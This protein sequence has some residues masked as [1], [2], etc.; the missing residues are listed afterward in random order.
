[1]SGGIRH[2]TQKSDAFTKGRWSKANG[3][4]ICESSLANMTSGA[5]IMNIVKTLIAAI[6]LNLP[7]ITAVAAAAEPMKLQIA[8]TGIETPKGAIMMV[9]FDSEAA[10][11]A[12]K[13]VR[14]VM[15][16]AD[17]TDVKT[18]VEGLPAGR[19]AIKSFHDIDGDHQMSVNP[20]GMP[21]EPFAFSNNAKGNMGP[22]TWADAAFDVKAGANTH[23]ITIQ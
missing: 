18:I 4:I 1:V 2:L 21:T 15:V 23:S 5:S 8:F 10:Y 13:P 20:Y 17:A 19:Y 11:N 6:A 22:A 7:A 9:L 3:G 12:E 16:P 14:A